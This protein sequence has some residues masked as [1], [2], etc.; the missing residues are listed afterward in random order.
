MSEI[1]WRVWAEFLNLQR[2]QMAHP[3][4]ASL[5]SVFGEWFLTATPCC[6][7]C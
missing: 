5:G 3:F 4:A 7:R 6:S 2:E 1:I